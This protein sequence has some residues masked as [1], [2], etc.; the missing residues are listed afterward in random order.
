M[1]CS[2]CPQCHSRARWFLQA[3]P[4]IQALKAELRR[5]LGERSWAE[6]GETEQDQRQNRGYYAITP[7]SPKMILL[8][9]QAQV[10]GWIGWRWTIS[11]DEPE[12]PLP[13][14]MHLL[15]RYFSSWRGLCRKGSILAHYRRQLYLYKKGLMSVGR[16]KVM[17][18]HTINEP[19]TLQNIDDKCWW[20]LRMTWQGEGAFY[21][22]CGAK[23]IP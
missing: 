16:V 4:R 14:T 6:L 15:R 9:T 2:K 19:W 20:C 1:S 7:K 21:P 13:N 23:G 11:S 18:T 10:L 3:A 12:V 8:G 22:K 5:P 17:L